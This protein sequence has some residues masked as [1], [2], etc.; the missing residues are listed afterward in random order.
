MSPAIEA[1]AAAFH[2]LAIDAFTTN[3]PRRRVV[4]K[5]GALAVMAATPA[6]GRI[7]GRQDLLGVLA[8]YRADNGDL[9]VA[10]FLIASSATS[11]G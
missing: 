11:H 2:A 5:E 7:H 1:L 6:A 9:P 4:V 8:L 3:L 10:Q